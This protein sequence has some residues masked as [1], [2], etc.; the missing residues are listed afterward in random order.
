MTIPILGGPETPEPAI[1]TDPVTKKKLAY[2]KVALELLSKNVLAVLVDALT[3]NITE[4]VV[5][6]VLARLKDRCAHKNGDGDLC[7]ISRAAHHCN[8]H[9]FT[10][11]TPS[12][13]G[14]V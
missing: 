5:R 13:N 8:S 3:R 4:N 1:V 7:R 10:E 14:K 11:S 6:N 2:P 9:D 12:A